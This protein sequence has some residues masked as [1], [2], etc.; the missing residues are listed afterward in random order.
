MIVHRF[1]KS[2]IKLGFPGRFAYRTCYIICSTVH[3]CH[4][5]ALRSRI[6]SISNY[7]SLVKI[8]FP[9]RFVH[10]PRHPVHLYHRNAGA[11]LQHAPVASQPR[12]RA[13]LLVA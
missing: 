9:G 2:S 11:L 3:H 8:G 7:L 13:L 12:Q 1:L 4:A 5:G 10:R 6:S